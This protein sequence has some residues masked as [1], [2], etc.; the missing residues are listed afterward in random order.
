MRYSSCRDSLPA[1]L[2]DS[3]RTLAIV[4]IVE[5]GRLGR[6]GFRER[7]LALL[8]LAPFHRGSARGWPAPLRAPTSGFARISSSVGIFGG[9]RGR[10]GVAGRG[11]AGRRQARLHHAVLRREPVVAAGGA[12]GGAPLARRA[13]G[14]GRSRGRPGWA[15]WR[16]LRR[17][18]GCR[19]HLLVGRERALVLLLAHVDVRVLVHGRKALPG[20]VLGLLG[21]D[22]GV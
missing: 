13:R 14:C 7:L 10:G 11:G 16:R 5:D 1:F 8:G 15:G 20:V 18:G 3:A 17:P 9:D 21:E 4:A 6:V 2:A 12:A 22:A 19:C